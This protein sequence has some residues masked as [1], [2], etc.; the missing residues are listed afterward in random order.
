MQEA[1][2]Y[3]RSVVEGIEKPSARRLIRLLDLERPLG[4]PASQ[5]EAS[6][7]RRTGPGKVPLLRYFLAT[8]AK[9]PQHLLLVRVGEFYE[10]VGLDAVLLVQ[11]AG[12]N[13]MGDPESSGGVPRAG[14]PRANLRRTVRDLVEGAGLS[15]VV[16][17]EEPEP[18]SYGA[19]RARHKTRYVAAVVTPAAPH[20]LLGLADGDADAALEA[21]PPVLGL[22]STVGGI[23]LIE[24][25]P[26]LR[27]VAVTEGLT[28]DAVLA[29]LHEGGLAPPLFVHQQAAGGGAAG[30]SL[31]E[32][33][34]EAEWEL[35]VREIF[36]QRLGAVVRYSGPDAVEGMLQVLRR[37]L[38]LPADPVLTVTRARA[39]ERP[40]PLYHSSA[41]NLG[42]HKARGVPPLLDSVVGA[43][44]P[45]PSRRWLRRLLL[46]P[47]PPAV[48]LAVHRACRELTHTHAALPEFTVTA[49]AN[50]VLKIEQRQASDCFFREVKIYGRVC[51]GC[52]LHFLIHNNNVVF[53]RRQ[54]QLIPL[55]LSAAGRPLL[56]GGT[57]LHRPRFGEPGRRPARGGRAG[58]GPPRGADGPGNSLSAG[59]GAHSPGDRPQA[60]PGPGAWWSR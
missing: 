37:Q 55:S 29:R 3:W 9:F 45:L 49:A 58:D 48:G 24:A 46:L 8:K 15:V 19:V 42:L 23:T 11:H 26:E 44:A 59:A 33:G 47:P 25:Q 12:L 5:V 6:N 39:G 7:A 36:R 52:L 34:V 4:L 1:E 2:E 17:E 54:R 56:V 27:R 31:R 22:S 32:T 53:I 60:R 20:L 21:A 38:A 40:R 51:V 10:T 28:E 14:C 30:R 41:V 18:Y 57:S 43:G 16:C 35:R 50:L 13:P